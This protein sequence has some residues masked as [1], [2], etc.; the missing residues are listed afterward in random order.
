MWTAYFLQR[1]YEYKAHILDNVTLYLVWLNSL[2]ILDT[3]QKPEGAR[4]ATEV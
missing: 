4:Q 1:P 3:L 2:Q